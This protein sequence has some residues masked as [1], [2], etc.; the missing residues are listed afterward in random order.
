MFAAPLLPG[1]RRLVSMRGSAHVHA[2]I[3]LPALHGVG[4]TSG[5]GPFNTCCRMLLLSR[6]TPLDAL[7]N[8]DEE[9]VASDSTFAE[10]ELV[11]EGSNSQQSET[12]IDAED[13][14]KYYE[15]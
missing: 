3:L 13:D 15:V 14:G 2:H 12:A 1:A 4:G 7:R 10:V 9:S 6:V 11:D 5:C 8:M